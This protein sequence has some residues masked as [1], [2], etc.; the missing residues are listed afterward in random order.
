MPEE[1]DD[2]LG[3]MLGD[4]LQGTKKE[5]EGKDEVGDENKPE[6][7]SVSDPDVIE[8]SSQQETQSAQITPS[9]EPTQSTQ[10]TESTGSAESTLEES[11]DDSEHEAGSK[12][13]TVRSRSPFPLYVTPELKET[14]Q[15]RFEKFNAQRTLNDEPQVEKHKHFMEGLLR[16]GLDNSDLEE[17]VLEEFDEK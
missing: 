14:V 16:A 4:R 15:S 10:S 12:E 6:A 7:E 5:G 3:Q 9:T 11:K 1:D 2:A 13:G 8:S 17:Y